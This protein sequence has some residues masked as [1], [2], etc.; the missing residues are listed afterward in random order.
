VLEDC[1]DEERG[2]DAIGAA[3]A[4]DTEGAGTAGPGAEAFFGAGAG[5]GAVDGCRAGV[6]IRCCSL[7]TSVA[8]LRG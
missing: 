5:A 6:T 4:G 2:G 3:L 8:C 7:G 1:G